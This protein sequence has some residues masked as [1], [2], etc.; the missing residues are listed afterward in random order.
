MGRAGRKKQTG[1]CSALY[2][3]GTWSQGGSHSADCTQG[4]KQY[5]EQKA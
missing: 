5:G 2:A 3:C 4:S 1:G